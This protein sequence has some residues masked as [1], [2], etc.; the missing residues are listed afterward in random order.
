M[1]VPFFR[2]IV[3]RRN[4]NPISGNGKAGCLASGVVFG[5]AAMRGHMWALWA[6]CACRAQ[7][8]MVII[9]GPL[10]LR[11][12][13]LASPRMAF[14]PAA[15]SVRAE[16]AIVSAEDFDFHTNGSCPGTYLGNSTHV[17]GKI[18]VA[19]SMPWDSCSYEQ[20][21]RELDK[22][23]AIGMANF[24]ADQLAWDP[25]PGFACS[26]WRRGD[27][28]FLASPVA[29]D[30][31]SRHAND[32]VAALRANA[33]VAAVLAPSPDPYLH[34]YN[35][36][37]YLALQV[38][39]TLQ[40]VLVIEL[41]MVRLIS[42][43]RVDGGLR[44]TIP[45]LLLTIEIVTA[46]LRMVCV[47]VDPLSRMR[48]TDYATYSF[49]LSCAISLAQFNTALFLVYFAEAASSAGIASFLISTPKYKRSLVAFAVCLACFDNAMTALWFW[50][51][52][53]LP[54][55][56][57]KFL[58]TGAAY[59]SL[60]LLMCVATSWRVQQAMAL[61]AAP[62]V[63]VERMGSGVRGSLILKLTDEQC[64]AAHTLATR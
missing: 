11:G 29:V 57:C 35:S 44:G 37:A 47:T 50:T 49:S 51:D 61:A 17:A 63:V 56:Y 31:T 7:A 5:V 12:T 36:L 18:V 6:L 45:Q 8:E 38:V 24:N 55:F 33:K 26:C 13:R 43:L 25:T 20:H 30:I 14:S 19:V 60:L 53:R 62:P 22:H 40:V 41:A 52:G 1:E 21:A 3:R 28:R 4:R 54:L 23:G 16:L 10:E 27:S 42:F 64:V 39:L 9:D 32:L 58:I 2:S 59:P 15:F 48:Y 46:L 34:M